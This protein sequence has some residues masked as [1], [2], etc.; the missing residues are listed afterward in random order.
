MDYTNTDF[1][2]K[3]QVRLLC[4]SFLN[5]NNKNWDDAWGSTKNMS[6]NPETATCLKSGVVIHSLEPGSK[7]CGK[8]VRRS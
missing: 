3:T 7:G 2:K 5:Y 1:K 4:S 6:K 8:R